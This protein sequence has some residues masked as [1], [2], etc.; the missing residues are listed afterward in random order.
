MEASEVQRLARNEAFFREVN[1]RIDDVAASLGDDDHGY[2]YVCECSNPACT[3]RIE[4]TRAAYEHVREDG[5][6]FVLA[7]GHVTEAIESVVERE[8]EHVLIEKTGAAAQIVTA[9]DPRA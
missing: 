9:L 3:E 1:E 5:T 7:P 2:E 4:L 8:D 6:R